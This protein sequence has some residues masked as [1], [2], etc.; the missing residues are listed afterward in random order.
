MIA[1]RMFGYE[2]LAER[3]DYE[4]RLLDASKWLSGVRWVDGRFPGWAIHLGPLHF[5]ACRL[6]SA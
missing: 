5:M 2:W 1:F 6:A 4:A 3:W